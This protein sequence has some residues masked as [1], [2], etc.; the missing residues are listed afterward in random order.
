MN[1]MGERCEI[2]LA[3]ICSE[4]VLMACSSAKGV[5]GDVWGQGAEGHY[6]F[7][8]GLAALLGNESDELDSMIEQARDRSV[9]FQLRHPETNIT[10]RVPDRIFA[11]LGFTPKGP[12]SE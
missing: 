6:A 12:T 1:V 10:E 5:P 11:E 2:D 8:C 4:R 3:E 9:A 7:L